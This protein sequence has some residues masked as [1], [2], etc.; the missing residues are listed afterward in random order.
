MIPYLDFK[1]QYE[2][3]K[4]EVQGAVERVFERGWFILGEEGKAFEDEFAS[5]CGCRFGV[6]V[7]SGT[8]ALHLS[9]VAIGVKNGDEVITV[10][11]T[12]VPTVSAISFAG[13]KPVFVDVLPGTLTMNPDKLESFITPRTKAII[14]VHLY[15]QM[16]DMDRI[17][18]IADKHNIP[19]VEDACQAHGAEYKEKKAGS[20]GTLGAF[21]FYPSKNL[22]AYGD[23]GMITTNNE[24]LA[25]KL[26]MLRNYG[27]SKRYYHETIG[28]NSRLDEI[29]ASIL[30]E[31]LKFLDQWIERRRAIAVKYRVGIHS[32]KISLP[33]E[34]PNRTHAYHLFVVRCQERNRLEEYL[35][36]NGIGTLIHYPVPVHIQNAYKWL[37]NRKGDFPE[38]ER[39]AEE[40]LSLPCYPELTDK[41]ITTVC[42]C[43]NRF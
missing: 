3:I 29:Q 42:D 12:A 31:K 28:F 40:V 39:A 9:L 4:P 6:G 25:E 2:A 10:P 24:T 35:K 14:P 26:R 33:E 17:N 37:G 19:I 11:N 30:R 36:G 20:W 15:G 34:A 16:A 13:A 7:G 41:E 18:A 5:Y 8:E 32:D 43:I 38:A 1:R 22:G 27:Q 21:S 23:G